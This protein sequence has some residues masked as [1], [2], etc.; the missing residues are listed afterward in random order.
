MLRGDPQPQSSQ[1]RST[2]GSVFPQSAFNFNFNSGYD[3]YLDLA[4][5]HAH[6]LTEEP[7]QEMDK[8]INLADLAGVP[9]SEMGQMHRGSLGSSHGMHGANQLNVGGMPVLPDMV[10]AAGAGGYAGSESLEFPIMAMLYP[11]YESHMAESVPVPAPYTH[12]DPTQLISGVDNN[13]LL[14]RTYHP[15][16][17]SDEWGPGGFTSSSTASPEPLHTSSSSQSLAE[18]HRNGA[19]RPPPPARRPTVGRKMS[20]GTQAA[21]GKKDDMGK[22][23]STDG[24]DPTSRPTSGEDGGEMTVC[25]NCQTTNTPLWRRDPEGQPLCEYCACFFMVPVFFWFLDF[26]ARC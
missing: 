15:S 24:S 21:L 19:P 16:P 26:R 25:T 13:D 17:S 2:T 1:R 14:M 12:V 8:N 18:Q 3:S 23:S 6:A 4:N 7:F 22:R 5:G 11:N 20:G 10:S 9:R